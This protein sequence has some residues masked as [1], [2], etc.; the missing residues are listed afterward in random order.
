[1]SLTHVAP[2]S[3]G[4]SGAA[5]SLLAV[6]GLTIAP[7]AASDRPLVADV[8]FTL[9]RGEA[10]GVVGE[11]GCGKSLTCLA[12]TGLLPRALLRTAGRVALEGT[13][14]ERLAPD[15]LAVVRG[16]RIG[17]IFQDPVASLN[18]VRTIGAFLTSLLRRHRGLQGEA[19]R[20]EAVRLLD[21]VG[22]AAARTRLRLYPHELSGGQNQRVMIAGALA[23]EPDVLLADEPTTALDVTTQAQ[24][25]DLLADLRATRGMALVVVSHDFGV[26]A[27]AADRVV[28]MY[29]GRVVEEAPVADLFRAPRHPYTAGLMASVPPETGRAP[30][31][32][33]L[34]QPPHTGAAVVGCAFA[35]RCV[36]ASDACRETTP[37][38]VQLGRRRVACRH[39]LPGERVS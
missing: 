4:S 11:S 27:A 30:L 3:A 25:L 36:R 16:R 34:G 20:R 24:I 2:A 21:A 17:M 32:P 26:I 33:L 15:A 5:A 6:E 1:M 8:A 12:I 9:G 14:I 22:V 19:A 39:P 10:L 38:L 13:R 31:R 35:P 37:A 28:V 23:G 18:P 29:A 7:R